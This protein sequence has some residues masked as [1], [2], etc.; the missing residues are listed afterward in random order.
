MAIVTLAIADG[1]GRPASARV[2]ILGSD[3]RWHAPR[4]AWMHGDEL[5]DRT[6]FPSEVHYFHCQSQLPG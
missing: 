5:Y 4:D 6:Q 2:S 1:S 3:A